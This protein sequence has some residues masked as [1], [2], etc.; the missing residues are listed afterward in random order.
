[1]FSVRAEFSEN[2]N[3]FLRQIQ[4]QANKFLGKVE[5]GA[6]GTHSN[7]KRSITMPDLAA[8]HEY[9]APSRNI[10]ERSF[11]R[12]SITLNQGKY[13]KYL[14]GEV[15]DLLLL[16]TTPTKIK[17]V[18]GMQAAADVQMYMVNGKFTPLKAKTIKRK[19]S[20]KPLIDTGQLRQSITYRVVD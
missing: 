11:L 5:V 2:P 3:W 9:G 19:G 4:N 17:Q 13:G 16:R 8:I 7:G 6:F 15:K 1:M 10:P 20:S 18:L 14:L 12:A